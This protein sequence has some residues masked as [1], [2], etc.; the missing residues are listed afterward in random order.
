MNP[1][2]SIFQTLQRILEITRIAWRIKLRIGAPPH[3]PSLPRRETEI[4]L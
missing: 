3:L 4:S 1:F 2:I